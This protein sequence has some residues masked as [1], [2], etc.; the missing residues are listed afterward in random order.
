MKDY[1]H[2]LTGPMI[3]SSLHVMFTK[4]LFLIAYYIIH[5]NRFDKFSFTDMMYDHRD[6]RYYYYYCKNSSL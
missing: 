5:I 1:C 2:L 4:V 6:C 3:I